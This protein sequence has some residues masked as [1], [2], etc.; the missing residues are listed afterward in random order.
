MAG[1]EARA[2]ANTFGPR[3]MRLADHLAQWS[4]QPDALTVTYFSEAHRKVATELGDLLRAA[5]MEVRTDAIGNVIGRYESSAPNARTLLLGSHYDTVRDG[6]KY[7]GRL[8]ILLPLVLIEHLNRTQQ[9]LPFHIELCC[10][11]EE[12]GVRFPIGYLGSQV[13]AGKFDPKNLDATDDA[14][15]QLRKVLQ[16]GGVD[17]QSIASLARKKDDL[18]GYVEVHIEQGPSLL[19]ANI[20]IAVVTGIAGAVRHRVVV[21]GE[22]GHAGTVA[23][24]FRHDAAAAAAEMIL[25][26][27]RLC[28]GMPSLVGTVGQLLVPNG[29]M[30]VIPGRCEFST[31]IRASSNEVRDAAARDILASF[32]EIAKRRGVKVKAEEVLRMSAIPLSPYFQERLKAA[33][34]RLGVNPLMLPSGAG[35][36]AAMMAGLTESAMMFVRCGNGGVS[37]SPREIITEEDADFSARVLFGFLINLAEEYNA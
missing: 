3:I 22:A 5:G 4:E 14:G 27:E 24:Q 31:D 34:E 33:A 35:H 18:I 20:P 30:N 13:I 10:F 1:T 12:E 36:D 32:E 2:G 23:M 29:A 8:G 7:D 6:G 25:A 9:R 37:H 15:M 16:D 21:K 11:A 26:V 28:G 19:N 17:L